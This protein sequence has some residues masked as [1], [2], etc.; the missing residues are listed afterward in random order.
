MS[1]I[2][3]RLA[4]AGLLASTA[5]ASKASAADFTSSSDGPDLSGVRLQIEAKNYQAA[6]TDLKG[7]VVKYEKP[8]VYSLLGYTLRKTGDRAEAMT[9]YQKALAADPTHPR[10]AGVSR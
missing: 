2:I 1:T 3:L 9:Y 5:I 8:D 10:G 6:L 7:I 4:L